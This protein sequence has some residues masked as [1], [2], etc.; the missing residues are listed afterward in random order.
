MWVQKEFIYPLVTTF[1]DRGGV[2][3]NKNRK[4]RDGRD[5]SFWGGERSSAPLYVRKKNTGAF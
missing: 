4:Q 3:A 2:G 1:W 5:M